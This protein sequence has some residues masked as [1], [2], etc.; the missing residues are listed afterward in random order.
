MRLFGYQTPLY[1]IAY[2]ALISLGSSDPAP[3]YRPGQDHA[4]F[5]A[6]SE[7]ESDGLT[8]LPQPIENARAI[9][10]ELASRYGFETELVEN[11]TLVEIVAKLTEYQQAY[12]TGQKPRDGQLFVFFAGHGVKAYGN[13]YFLPADADPNQ[14]LTTAL[15]YNTWRPFIDAIPC[16]HILVAIDACYSV[17]FD[18]NWQAMGDEDDR[19]ARRGELSEAERL[20]ADHEQYPARLFFTSDAQEDI[21]PGRSNFA[22]KLLE[23][24]AGRDRPDGILTAKTLFANYV[25]NARPAAN[26]GDFGGDDPR[27]N[28]LFFPAATTDPR[29]DFRGPAEA[30]LERLEEEAR[31]LS[32]WNAAK[33]ANTRQAYQDF[34]DAYP[35]SPYRALAEHNRDALPISG[36]TADDLPAMVSIRGGTFQMGSTEGDGDEKPVHSVTVSDF[37][38]GRYEVTVGAFAEFIAATNY[39]TDAEKGGDSY[40]WTGSSWE[41]KAGVTWRDDTAGA[42]RSRSDYDHPVIHVSWNDAVAYCNWLSE[43]HGYTPV[44]RI[45]GETVTANWGANGYRLPT[46]AEWEYAARSR[47][48][49]DTWAGTSS[50]SELRRYANYS[51]DADGFAGTAPVGSLGANDL[52]LHDMS[53]NVW[54]WCWDWHDS[55]YYGNSPQRDPRGPD[56]GADRV[57]R[58]GSWITFAGFC[59]AALRDFIRPSRRDNSL[60]FRLARSVE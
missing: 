17:T 50:E 34:I 48:G 3:T 41:S 7:Y 37:K 10:G 28:F 5:F 51:G 35:N 54:E 9:A 19:F 58:G 46:E 8:D 22:R 6:V 18:P 36:T 30:A 14:V 4:L 15:G 52:G 47:G 60:G 31:E 1:L 23:G 33:S 20:L 16:Q 38:L 49:N 24:L 12:A 44:Y 32:A 39:Q 2:F 21:V 56:S 42:P 27:S 45:S 40:I 57:G 25:S 53:G 13:G 11:P 59:R 26:A 55:G 43:Q 29:G